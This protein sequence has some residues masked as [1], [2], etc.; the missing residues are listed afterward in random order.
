MDRLPSAVEIARAL[1]A[2]K[3]GG[4]WS[5]RCPSHDDRSPSLSIGVGRDGR[6]LVHCH[7]GCTQA[8]VIGA[9]RVLGI[10]P[11]RGDAS[12]EPPRSGSI[13]NST[14]NHDE[15]KRREAARLIWKN[16]QPIADTL[17]EAY[18]RERG[19][20]IPLPPTLRFA[21]LFHTADRREKPAVVCAIQDG[22]GRVTAVQRIFLRPDGLA[23]TDAKPNKP[24]LGPM[25]DGAVRL[26]PPG[27]SLG[28]AEG[29]ETALSAQQRFCL[30]VW[31]SCGAGR[32]NKVK[33]PD[34]VQDIY[35]FAD[36]GVA[37]IKAAE[38]TAASLARQGFRTLVQP[39][40]EGDWNDVVKIAQ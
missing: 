4:G 3:T 39:P 7:S 27:R 24:T 28:L 22:H 40:E 17:G 26:G 12:K 9:L 6:P 31:C 14:A 8:E 30:P 19:I 33:I 11:E 32:M 23:K 5:A 35:I 10:W 36:A 15:A 13:S 2:K 1:E 38:K 34:R 29:P 20:K 25:R 21:R 18:L 16:A 37:G